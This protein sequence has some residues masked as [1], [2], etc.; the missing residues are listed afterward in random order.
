MKYGPTEITELGDW[1]LIAAYDKCRQ[2]QKLRD[3]ASEHDKFNKDSSKKKMEFPP[4]NPNFTQMK[5]EIEN[6]MKKR[7]LI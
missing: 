1:A 4:I 5:T 2:A 3:K 6:E 7:K